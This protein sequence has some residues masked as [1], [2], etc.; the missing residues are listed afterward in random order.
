MASP[1][2]LDGIRSASPHAADDSASVEHTPSAGV[3][4]GRSSITSAAPA[5]RRAPE[6]AVSERNWSDIPVLGVFVNAAYSAGVFL[7]NLVSPLLSLF[8]FGAEES[9]AAAPEPEARE[10]LP[11]P[12]A[13]SSTATTEVVDHAA[14]PLAAAREG[15]EAVMAEIAAFK[16]GSEEEVA[17][18]STPVLANLDSLDGVVDSLKASRIL[19]VVEAEG[20]ATDATA[21]ARVAAAIAT[22]EEGVKNEVFGAA[23]LAAG[24]PMDVSPS[25]GQEEVLERHNQLDSAEVREVLER[26]SGGTTRGRPTAPPSPAPSEASSS[27]RSVATPDGLAPAAAVDAE[28]VGTAVPFGGDETTDPVAAPAVTSATEAAEADETAEVG[29]ASS[30]VASGMPSTDAAVAAD[31]PETGVVAAADRAESPATAADDDAASEAP[32]LD[33]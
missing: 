14:A 19:S 22:L 23:W 13:A 8:G 5:E 32:S 20:F 31:E 28:P 16:S 30:V 25:F 4:A 3:G 6:A 17:T 24:S 10:G 21:K 18:V 1:T 2:S 27:P 26:V 15:H 11:V 9:E 33:T 29:D 12:V 7:Y